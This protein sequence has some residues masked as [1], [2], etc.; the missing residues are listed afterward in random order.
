MIA[1]SHARLG[2]ESMRLPKNSLVVGGDHHAAEG[3]GALG[4][5]PHMLEH[6][7]AGKDGERFTGETGGFVA[8]WD[9]SQDLLLHDRSYHENSERHAIFGVVDALAGGGHGEQATR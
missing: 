8:G 7:F 2:F 4:P 3:P 9:N 1:A 6:A 5:L